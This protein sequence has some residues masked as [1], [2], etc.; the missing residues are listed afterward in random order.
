MT[1]VFDNC[2]NKIKTN[3]EQVCTCMSVEIMWLYQAMCTQNEFHINNTKYQQKVI[4]DFFFVHL[5]PLVVVVVVVVV[6][7]Y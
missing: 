6:F 3:Y 1:F 5:L 2:I 7:F 4:C